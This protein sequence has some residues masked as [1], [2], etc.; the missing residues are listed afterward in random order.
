MANTSNTIN[1]L[2]AENTIIY[3]GGRAAGVVADSTTTTINNV[4]SK[5]IVINSN[6]IVSGVVISSATS[7][8]TISNA[9]SLATFAKSAYIVTHS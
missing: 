6:G 8:V 4:Y 9:Y 2:G 1:I 5:D 3:G 7:A